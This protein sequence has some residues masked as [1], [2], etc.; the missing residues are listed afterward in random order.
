MIQIFAYVGF[1]FFNIINIG[2][3]TVLRFCFLNMVAFLE[4][5]FVLMA[6][7]I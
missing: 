6:F 2:F 1:F 4:L 5:I 3:L 7:D